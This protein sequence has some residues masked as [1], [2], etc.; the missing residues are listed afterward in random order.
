M[1]KAQ[2]E[3]PVQLEALVPLTKTISSM[4][5]D[6]RRVSDQTNLIALNA[7]IEAARAGEAGRGFAIVA[8]EIRHLAN[9]AAD[10]ADK[11]IESTQSISS[12]VINTVETINDEISH[13]KE[14]V[15][16]ATETLQCLE[17]KYSIILSG[18]FEMTS[19][20]NNANNQIDNEIAQALPH[21]QFE[22]RY[23]QILGNLESGLSLLEEKV[24]VAI[25]DPNITINSNDVSEWAT[26]MR[27][28]YTTPEERGA[29]DAI[30]DCKQDDS[31]PAVDS[32]DIVFL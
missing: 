6:V 25:N 20:L 28:L 19:I 30:F 14:S 10:T 27:G 17:D 4:V 12:L 9:A 31:G 29:I 18:V 2:A 7:A 21:F 22:D 15:D 5:E 3:I 16:S 1:V 24:S 11:I 26:E 8:E 13:N 32:G 23:F